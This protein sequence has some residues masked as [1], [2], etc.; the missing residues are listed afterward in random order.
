MRPRFSLRTLLIITGMFAGF[1]Y[2]WIVM[3]TATAKRFMDVIGTEDYETA[4]L[5]FWNSDDR[6]LA[7]WKEHRWGFQSKAELA[8]WSLIQL[9]SGHRN[10]QLHI[11]YFQF[12]QNHDIEMRIEAT[13]FGVKSPKTGLTNTSTIVDRAQRVILNR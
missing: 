3:P 5:F 12:D 13:S 10:L 2:Y 11:S 8:P 1:C 4:D 7:D 9:L 6:V